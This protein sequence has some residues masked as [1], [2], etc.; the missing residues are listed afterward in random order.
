HQYDTQQHP[1]EAWTSAFASRPLRSPGIRRWRTVFPT[2]RYRG[3]RLPFRR[4][5][6][7]LGATPLPP[8]TGKRHLLRLLMLPG[9]TP[10][11]APPGWPL[12]RRSCRTTPGIAT[13]TATPT[14]ALTAVRHR[15]PIP[16]RLVTVL[17]R[18][19]IHG[20]PVYCPYQP[21]IRTSDA[22][23]PYGITCPSSHAKPQPSPAVPHRATILVRTGPCPGGSQDELG[24]QPVP[25]THPAHH[26]VATA[27]HYDT[28]HTRCTGTSTTR[29]TVRGRRAGRNVQ[30][31][32][33]D[34]HGTPGHG[35]A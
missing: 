34:Q 25:Q 22:R 15:S 18:S 17:H 20:S 2:T 13:G 24:H 30:G 31:S 14:G 32:V 27:R 4:P 8:S 33:S 26:C 35:R 28:C 5:V 29:V 9:A 3:I 21:S 1:A 12:R 19:S 23:L 16:S 7:R 10:S 11:I 6:T